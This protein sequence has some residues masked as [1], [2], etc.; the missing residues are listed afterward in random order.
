[1][2]EHTMM[3]PSSSSPPPPPP[4]PPPTTSRFETMES[5]ASTSGASSTASFSFVIGFMSAL[6]LARMG[7]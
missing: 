1:M 7:F 3:M 2:K 4:P 6:A 5:D